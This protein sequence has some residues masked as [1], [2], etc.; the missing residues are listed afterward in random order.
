MVLDAIG[1][2]LVGSIH[3]RIMSQQRIWTT[4]SQILMYQMGNN[5]CRSTNGDYQINES[6]LVVILVPLSEIPYWSV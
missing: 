4:S 3:V 6:A 5:S 1:Q 2:G